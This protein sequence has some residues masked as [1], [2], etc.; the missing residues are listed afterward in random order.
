MQKFLIK[1]T[2]YS[3]Q[4]A[5]TF[6]DRHHSVSLGM[7]PAT[8]PLLP[9]TCQTQAL[10]ANKKQPLWPFFCED[11]QIALFR[12]CILALFPPVANTYCIF[13][14]QPNAVCVQVLQESPVN[15]VRK[16]THFYHFI[17]T[18]QYGTKMFTPTKHGQRLCLV[19]EFSLREELQQETCSNK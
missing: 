4:T 9:D 7:L 14:R 13:R 12:S 2:V 10:I 18:V 11:S 8:A 6:L 1:E 16:F 17:V 15:R 3:F 19:K 5:C